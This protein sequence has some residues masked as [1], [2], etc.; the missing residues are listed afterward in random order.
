LTK[1]L[2]QDGFKNFRQVLRQ[3]ND[4]RESSVV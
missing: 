4:Q 3:A 2:G 1:D